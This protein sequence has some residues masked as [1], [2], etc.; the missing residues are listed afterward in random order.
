M[1]IVEDAF[2]ELDTCS[3]RN[4]VLIIGAPSSKL[5]RLQI[6]E[7]LIRWETVRQ[8]ESK[9]GLEELAEQ[10]IEQCDG[11][12]LKQALEEFEVNWYVPPLT[13]YETILSNKP[14]VPKPPKVL[15]QTRKGKW[16]NPVNSYKSRRRSKRC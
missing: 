1:E 13:T 8:K 16:I 14:K 15:Y 12:E 11:D 7:E 3:K 2:R 4:K 6:L 9:S 10:I 5:T